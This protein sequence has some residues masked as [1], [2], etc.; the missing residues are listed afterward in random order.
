MFSAAVWVKLV[1]GPELEAS[2][3]GQAETTSIARSEIA[4]AA[5]IDAADLA[6]LPSIAYQAHAVFVDATENFVVLNGNKLQVGSM[7]GEW[8]ID[9]IYDREL[10]LSKDEQLIRIPALTAV[11]L[12]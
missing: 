5:S 10:V 9:A 11:E 4:A 12:P 7:I 3:K 6:G 2:A 8:Q 1:L